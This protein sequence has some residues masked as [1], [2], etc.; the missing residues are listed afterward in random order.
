MDDRCCKKL[1]GKVFEGFI[2]NARTDKYQ[3]MRSIVE[4]EKQDQL[5]CDDGRC[6]GGCII[7]S[8]STI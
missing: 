1:H 5:S 4:H 2:R 6:G 7:T 3:I 8:N